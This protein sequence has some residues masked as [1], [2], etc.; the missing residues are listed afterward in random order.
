MT[1]W[2]SGTA[3]FNS[4][5]LTA[6]FRHRGISIAPLSISLLCLHYKCKPSSEFSCVFSVFLFIFDNL[7][8]GNK[9]AAVFGLKEAKER[10]LL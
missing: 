3:P 10:Q 7:Q 5:V 4:A 6:S 8:H 2:H 1:V 9:V